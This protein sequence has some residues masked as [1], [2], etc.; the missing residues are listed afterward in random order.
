MKRRQPLLSNFKLFPYQ[1]RIYIVSYTARD[2][3][4]LCNEYFDPLLYPHIFG[5]LI[6]FFPVTFSN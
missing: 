2:I 6:L 1:T 5:T 4:L 3:A